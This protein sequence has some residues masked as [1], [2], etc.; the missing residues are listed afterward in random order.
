MVVNV[1]TSAM[2]QCHENAFISEDTANVEKAVAKR[3]VWMSVRETKYLKKGDSTVTDRPY[4]VMFN[5]ESYQI[6]FERDPWRD[7]DLAPTNIWRQI[8][9]RVCS[10]D[11]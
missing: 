4:T 6:K 5:C 10:K 2:K 11:S 8:A 3:Q 1:D 7:I 9:K